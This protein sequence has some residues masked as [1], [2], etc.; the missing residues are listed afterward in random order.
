MAMHWR[1]GGTSE[2][3]AAIDGIVAE[4]P[5]LQR[6][7]ADNHPALQQP[8]RAAHQMQIGA[9]RVKLRIDDAL[10]ADLDGVGLFAPGSETTGIGR[11]STGLGCPHLETDPDFLGLMVAFQTGAGERVDFLAINNGAAPTDTV[12]EFVGLLAATAAAAGAEIPFGSAGELDLGNLTAAQGKLY[13]ALRKRLGLGRATSIFLHIAR[14]TLR[15]ALSSSAIQPY[16]TGVVE[17]STR[18]SKFSFVP[19]DEVNEHR[20]LRPG[21]RYLSEDW[22]GRVRAGAIGF[23]LHW[24]PFLDEKRTPLEKAGT[25][26]SEEHAVRVGSLTFEQADPDSRESRLLALLASEMGANPGN[27][28]GTRTSDPR[29][30]GTTFTAA[31][32]HG[33]ALSQRTREALPASALN[34]FFSSGGR[35]GAAL[36]LELLRRHHAK[37][38]SGHAGPRLNGPADAS[39]RDGNVSDGTD[40]VMTT[41]PVNAADQEGP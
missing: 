32:Q 25:A 38:S 27:W 19:I 1:F 3:Q 10:P 6:I 30:P 17:V 41:D 8:D 7:L 31:R 28:V 2:E 40:R 5:E 15:T 20:K 36:E 34:S 39:E 21:A 13:H 33:Y 24:I 14:Q 18:P 26:W 29:V 16:W 4:I 23:A 22:A 9:G 37:Q 35:I 11:I 12:E